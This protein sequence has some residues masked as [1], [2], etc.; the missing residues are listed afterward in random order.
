MKDN[1]KRKK[2]GEENKKIVLI[3]DGKPMR[4]FYT[5]IFF[6]RLRY[7]VITAKTAADALIYLGLTM[8]LVVIANID[9]PDMSGVDFLKR[10][11]KK[12][13]T[14]DIP[15]I[16][17]T[18]NKDPDNQRAC[19]KAGCTAYLRHPAT[20]EQLYAAV[21]KATNKPRRFVRLDTFLGVTIGDGSRGKKDHI[22]VLSEPGMFIA[23]DK[24]L[25]Y[26]SVHP[27]SFHL[28]NAPGWVI[29]VEGQVIH[30]IA[31]DDK[32]RPGIG[33]KFLKIGAQERELIKD[34][35]RETLMEG[36]NEE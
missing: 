17:F 27:F 12:D 36:V 26:G 24:Q 25:A 16:I 3:V 28:P 4:Q 2:E 32:R 1:R 13:R 11:K 30:R 10:L 31:S 18:S 20:L 7:N 35:I 34:F 6:Q 33:V 29:K 21:Q 15:V 19:E 14:R 5:S 23:T 8:P 22:V 9:L